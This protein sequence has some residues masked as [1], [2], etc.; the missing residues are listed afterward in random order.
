MLQDAH[1]S[2][3]EILGYWWWIASPGFMISLT[4]VAFILL[5]RSFEKMAKRNRKF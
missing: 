4:S 2:S 5:G 1:A 3:A